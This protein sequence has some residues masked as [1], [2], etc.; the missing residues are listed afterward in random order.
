MFDFCCGREVEGGE[1]GAGGFGVE[2][3]GGVP[4]G[5][6]D[7]AGDGGGEADAEEEVAVALE[8][9]EG[10]AEVVAEVEVGWHLK[11]HGIDFGV[12]DA[13]DFPVADGVVPWGEA[14]EVE[15]GFVERE[16]VGMHVVGDGLGGALRP[17]G[18]EDDA[19]VFDAAE[20]LVENFAVA[21]VAAADCCE[22]DRASD[23]VEIA[24]RLIGE[25]GADFSQGR[26]AGGGDER[27][28]ERLEEAAAQIKREGLFEREAEIGNAALGVD[29]PG[30][31]AVVFDALFQRE[32]GFG[33]VD[34]VA[35]DGFDADRELGHELLDGQAAGRVAK[36]ADQPPLPKDC[37]I[38][39][40]RLVLLLIEGHD[41]VP[42]AARRRML[43]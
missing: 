37:R 26:L 38:L 21:G 22:M 16:A 4:G 42:E 23:A 17:V 20:E 35:A 19:M 31:A 13:V 36:Q 7:V 29:A 30:F 41:D 15:R 11:G 9:A 27:A 25:G 6:L 33:K 12:F 32:A 3:L 43:A 24:E 14:D 34:Q 2:G 28:G 8:D 10:A 39:L 5:F 1:E 40:G 18:N